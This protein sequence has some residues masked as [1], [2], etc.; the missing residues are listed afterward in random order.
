VFSP[1][2]HGIFYPQANR[3]RGSGG[4]EIKWNFGL[5]ENSEQSGLQLVF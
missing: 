1:L 3:T 4:R 5:V 2:V